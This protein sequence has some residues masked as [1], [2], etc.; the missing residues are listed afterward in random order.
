M[1]QVIKYA[2]DCGLPVILDA[3]RNDIGSTAEAYAQACFGQHYSGPQCTT[4]AVT[5][6]AY[7]GSDGVK[8]FLKM[9]DKVGGGIFVLVKTSNPSSGEL[10]DL[11]TAT[12]TIYENV[13][14]LVNTWGEG[15]VGECGYSSVGA[16]V[17]A[18]YPEQLAQLRGQMPQ[19]IFLVPGYGA[20]GGGAADVAAAFDD[21]GFGAVVNSSRGILYAYRKTG[22]DYKT[23][24]AKAALVMRDDLNSVI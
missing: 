4:S 24:A 5:V 14:Q 18:T 6:N 9:A 13:A 10:Q 16:V 12:G 21:N 19:S 1:W 7:L 2:A 17:G 22:E 20:Q 8:P 15:R 23:A 11:E 3:K